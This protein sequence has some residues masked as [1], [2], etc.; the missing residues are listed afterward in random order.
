M[1]IVLGIPQR[2]TMWLNLDDSLLW[3]FFLLKFK[4]L[5]IIFFKNIFTILLLYYLLFLIFT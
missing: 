1:Y 5:K 2:Y 3:I 4:T